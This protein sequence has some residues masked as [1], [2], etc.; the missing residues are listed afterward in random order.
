M[1]ARL[2][3]AINANVMPDILIIDEALSVGDQTFQAKCKKRVRELL[4]D[5]SVTLL[6][7]SH[8]T[9]SAKAFC[10]RGMVIDKGEIMFDDSIEDA[11]DFYNKM[12]ADQKK[13]SK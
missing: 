5:G 13:N 3:F 10:K 6:F 7:V 12:L 1:R 11:I 9:A 2:G 8:S 4:E